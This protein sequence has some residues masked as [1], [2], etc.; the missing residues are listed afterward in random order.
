MENKKFDTFEW[1]DA[2]IKSIVI[3]RSDAGNN[4]IIEMFI[5]WPS[6][7]ESK[8]IFKDVYYAN[9]SLNFGVIAEDTI[10]DASIIDSSDIDIV[11]IK[12]KWAKYFVG[13]N[14]IKGF[15]ILTSSTV[16]TI[17]IFALSFER[18]DLS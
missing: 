12:N 16:S 8:I 1:H 11:N 4:D 6:E 7:V 2:I 5:I 17:R 9:L 15:E 10:M 13:I 14:D 3:D 18:I